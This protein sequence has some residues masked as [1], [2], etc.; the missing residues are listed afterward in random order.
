MFYFRKLVKKPLDYIIRTENFEGPF[1]LLLDLIKK[2]AMN[3]YDLQI[4]EITND[5]IASL[6][7]MQEQNIEITSNFMEMASILLEIKSKMLLPVEKEK[8][9]PRADLVR[10]L[11]EYQEYKESVER[12]RVLKQME[13]MLFKRQRIEKVKIKKT[14]NSEDIAKLYQSI[15]AKK[16]QNQNTYSPLDK[17]TE[18]LSRFRY[19]IED[20]MDALKSLLEENR[21]NVALY[22]DDMSDKEEMVVTFGA[23]LELVKIDYVDIIVENDETIFIEKRKGAE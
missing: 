23:L 3:I 21:V 16:F 9:D 8:G 13:Q 12:L 11:L 10:Q 1:E 14:G 7:Q 19:T 15:L 4:S 20:R 17:L 2:R 22:F 18:E 5:Y 6:H